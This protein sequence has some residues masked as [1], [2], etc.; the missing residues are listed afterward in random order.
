[1]LG[2]NESHLISN[3]YML[4]YNESHLISN[5]LSIIDLCMQFEQFHSSLYAHVTLNN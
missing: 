4:G 2:Y 3:F 1:M 5:F